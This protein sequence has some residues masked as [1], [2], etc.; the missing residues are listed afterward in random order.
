MQS[1]HLGN[2]YKYHDSQDIWTFGTKKYTNEALS[3]VERV[4]GTLKSKSI[5]LP[6]EDCHPELDE[7]PLLDL[8]GHRKFQMLI[9]MLQWLVTIGRPDLSHSLTSLNRFGACPC[10]THLELALHIFSYIKT[11]RDP[12]IAIDSR[13]LEY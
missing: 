9:G 13:T 4:F 12:K 6:V 8:D 5:A 2:N 7:S 3:R 11:V 1:K 10:E